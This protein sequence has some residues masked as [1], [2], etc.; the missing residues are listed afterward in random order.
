MNVVPQSAD[1][2]LFPDGPPAWPASFPDVEQ[3]LRDCFAHGDWGKYHGRWI[4]RLAET[5]SEM[6]GD[7]WVHPTCSGTAAVEL[8]LR[9]L[10]VQ[11][12]DRV[13]LAAY[14]FPGNF[15]AIEALGATPVLID[16]EPNRWTISAEALEHA[17]RQFQPAAAIVSH[18]HGD[19]APMRDIMDA[20]KRLALPIVEDFCQCPGA[21]IDGQRAGT[22]GELSVTSFGGSK[23]LT[24][25]R[26]GAIFGDDPV[27]QQ[28][29][30]IFNDQGNERFPLSELQACV[31]VPQLSLLE[32]ANQRRQ[33]AAAQFVAGIQDL[34]L[35]PV[36]VTASDA[37]RPAYYK[38]GLLSS[39]REK[40]RGPLRDLGVAIDAGFR[41]LL[42]RRR[43]CESV[44][45][46]KHAELIAENTLILHHPILGTDAEHIERLI[47]AFRRVAEDHKRRH[48]TRAGG[49]DD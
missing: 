40:W 18:L 19:L 47:A 17:A 2:P 22:W 27:H 24:A 33:T 1:E 8:A 9:A 35:Q 28:R 3:A 10:S 42:R 12:G 45:D 44:G 49:S 25:G 39:D 5:L 48:R 30:R 31:L 20:A 6:H 14:D 43:R 32:A 41:G 15:A 46:L 36:D 38:L 16:V 37:R 23:L 34:P 26:G 4:P 7:R 29:L 21:V 13:L 11:A